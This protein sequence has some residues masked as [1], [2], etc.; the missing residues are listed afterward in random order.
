MVG[1]HRIPSQAAEPWLC[2]LLRAIPAPAL[3]WKMPWRLRSGTVGGH[4]QG[5]RGAEPGTAGWRGEVCP[6]SS[7]GL[8]VARLATC[9]WPGR[10][11]FTR[12]KHRVLPNGRVSP[13]WLRSPAPCLQPPSC[14]ASSTSASLTSVFHF[15]SKVDFR[16]NCYG[17]FSSRKY[18]KQFYC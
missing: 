8:F 16:R 4:G 18:E 17:K 6:S 13:A 12:W 5:S 3:S 11:V 10:L 1:G 14:P 9:V 7:Q 2:A 15:H